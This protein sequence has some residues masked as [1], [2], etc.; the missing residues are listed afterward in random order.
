MV[1]SLI[2]NKETKLLFLVIHPNKTNILKN[3]TTEASTFLKYILLMSLEKNLE[4]GGLLITINF[5]CHV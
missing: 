2:A 3:P 5:N 1:E 4:L